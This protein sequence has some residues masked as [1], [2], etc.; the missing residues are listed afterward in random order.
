M[1]E[2]KTPT[3]VP[4]VV[5]KTRV[6]DES[7][8]GENPFRWQDVNSEDLFKG[9]KV[10]MFVLPGAFTPI[11]SSN[12]LPAYEAKYD[13]FKALGI[14]EVYCMAVN[15]AFVMYQWGKQQDI[16]NVKLIPDGS[17]K[18]AEAMGMLVKKDNVGYGNRSWRY[19]MYVDD[20]EIKKMFV[21]EGKMD[22]CPDDP[23]EVSDAE[24]MLKYLKELKG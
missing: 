6:R 8:P 13:E 4:N 14:D 3:H 7:V 23:F 20:G 22:D 18:F 16:K 1:T 12:H 24:T 2:S 15:D 10:V 17:G 21:E 5:L 9:K 11:C 19:S